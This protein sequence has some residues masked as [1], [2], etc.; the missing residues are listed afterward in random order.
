MGRKCPYAGREPFFRTAFF[1]LAEPV[2]RPCTNSSLLPESSKSSSSTTI[3]VAFVERVD[4]RVVVASATSSLPGSSSSLSVRTFLE[5][6]FLGLNGNVSCFFAFIP[7]AR[8]DLR[9][10]TSLASESTYA[11]SS[12]PPSERVSPLITSSSVSASESGL[13]SVS[14]GLRLSLMVTLTRELGWT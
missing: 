12:P 10:G 2:E 14:T 3:R 8:V 13:L 5:L 11:S 6:A 7:A 4:L 9:I 1:G